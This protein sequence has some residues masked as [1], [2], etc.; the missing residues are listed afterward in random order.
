[1]RAGWAARSGVVGALAL[2]SV[3][4]LAVSPAQACSCKGFDDLEALRYADAVFEGS[5]AGGTLRGGDG[6][7]GYLQ[8]ARF[9]VTKA[10]KGT[11]VSPQRVRTG[12]PGSCGLSLSGT[13]PFLVFV[14]RPSAED[15][16]KVPPERNP[17]E[18]VYEA[19][20]CGGTRLL[21]DGGA[22]DFGPATAV[23]ALPAAVVAAW[24]D[25]ASE[26]RSGRFV[27][28]VGAL[29]SLVVLGAVYGFTRR[30]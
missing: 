3:P 25:P 8:E 21:A 1:M 2:A 20:M 17:A 30:F 11:V 12:N 13:G 6:G 24:K 27:L 23:T 7:S 28:A 4:F 15:G 14:T 22:P 5:L 19:N 29:A 9:D 16:V 26:A 18:Q 10:Y